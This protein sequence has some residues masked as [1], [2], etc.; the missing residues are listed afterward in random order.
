ML[1]QLSPTIER[2]TPDAVEG[3]LPLDEAVLDGSASVK[4]IRAMSKTMFARLQTLEEGTHEYQY[5]RN[6]LIE[7]NMALVRY[8]T[9]RFTHRADQMEDMLQVGTIGLIKAVDRFDPDYGVEFVTF[10]LPT[11]IG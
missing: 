7:A 4:D 2:T 5:V 9:K 8:A 6:C 11:I 1:A 10:A 3:L